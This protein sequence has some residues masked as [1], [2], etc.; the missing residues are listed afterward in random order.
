[1]TAG[2]AFRR[3]APRP[4]LRL[5]LLLLLAAPLLAT[6]APPGFAQET[7]EAS[8]AAEA[9]DPPAAEPPAAPGPVTP[10]AECIAAL[11]RGDEPGALRAFHRDRDRLLR[12]GV[13]FSPTGADLLLLAAL[14]R[15]DRSALLLALADRLDPDPRRALALAAGLFRRGH[16]AK[17]AS[18]FARFLR[19]PA[20]APFALPALLLFLAALAAALACAVRS[21]ARIHFYRRVLFHERAESGAALPHLDPDRFARLP[22]RGARDGLYLSAAILVVALFPLLSVTVGPADRAARARAL[23]HRLFSAEPG[24]V[25]L[26]ELLAARPLPDGAEA[27]LAGFEHLRRDDLPEAR[28]AFELVEPAS[29]LSPA[30]RYGLALVEHRSGSSE[31]ALR[32]L[33]PLLAARP[34]SDDLQVALYAFARGAARDDIAQEAA[35]RLDAMPGGPDRLVDLSLA[36]VGTGGAMP[37]PLAGDGAALLDPAAAAPGMRA[38]ALALAG[39]LS[40]LLALHFARSVFAPEP[41][42]NALRVCGECG[43]VSCERCRATVGLCP[44]CFASLPPGLDPA[45]LRRAFLRRDATP[46]LLL[47]TLLFGFASH[48]AGRHAA[49]LALSFATWLA[50]LFDLLLHRIV[51]SGATPAVATLLSD[52]ADLGTL[53]F[54]LLFL[55]QLFHGGIALFARPSGK[56]R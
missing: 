47:A 50:L 37:A 29:P 22:D 31:A 44:R 16:P 11:D 24:A 40:G 12:R 32:R 13:G 26:A 36:Y 17:S 33:L 48:Q 21:L 56:G 53:L 10:F 5:L 46:S 8:P 4:C 52:S 54:R 25:P 9:A 43:R 27:A 1:M 6:T 34:G 41:D 3:R 38:L 23:A 51:A 49:A 14:D 45:V 55:L 7:V 30:A 35:R 18:A 19:G 42:A 28:R 2:P 15:P 39:I 20:A